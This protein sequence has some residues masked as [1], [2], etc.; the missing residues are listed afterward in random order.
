MCLPLSITPMGILLQTKC[1]RLRYLVGGFFRACMETSRKFH[2]K[3]QR[4]CWVILHNYLLCLFQY[5]FR[6]KFMGGYEL[7]LEGIMVWFP[8][9]QSCTVDTCSFCLG[10]VF[11][12]TD[13]SLFVKC[14]C[15]GL[16]Q[17]SYHLQLTQ[18]SCQLLYA[19]ELLSG[20]LAPES[21][22]SD[23]IERVFCC[24]LRNMQSRHHRSSG[25]LGLDQQQIWLK[26]AK[27]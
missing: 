25:Q 18:T 5:L 24:H 10:V 12:P 15:V 7:S 20:Q 8:Y 9:W 19:L 14:L 16:R 11:F 23:D 21:I 1:A 2:F 4:C 3:W 22:N 13:S 17:T 27:R 6:K 26:V